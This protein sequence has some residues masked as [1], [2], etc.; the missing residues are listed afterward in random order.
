MRTDKYLDVNIL[1]Q[2]MEYCHDQMYVESY[3]LEL[4]H[5]VN[6]YLST[7]YTVYSYNT[8]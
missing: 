5:F 7:F 8:L 4:T 6:F 1:P 2:H 3:S